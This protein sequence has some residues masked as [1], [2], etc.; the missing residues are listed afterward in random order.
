MSNNFYVIVSVILFSI[1][2]S[3]NSVAQQLNV[4]NDG[5]PDKTLTQ[6]NIAD[7][8]KIVA[9]ASDLSNY[10]TIDPTMTWG[11]TKEWQPPWIKFQPFGEL[12]QAGDLNGDGYEDYI[13][14]Y[15]SWNEFTDDLSD[16]ISKTLIYFGPDKLTEAADIIYDYLIP[17]GDV[18]GIGKSQLMS[19]QENRV[20][21]FYNFDGSSY[22]GTSD[23]VPQLEKWLTFFGSQYYTMLF[24]DLDGNQSDDLIGHLID[25]IIVGYLD[26][27]LRA[28]ILHTF[29]LND[30]FE[31]IYL[32]I[33][34]I[35]HVKWDN[36]NYLV[37]L[38]QDNLSEGR[39]QSLAV[40]SLD[41][42]RLELV[43]QLNFSENMAISVRL[44]LLRGSDGF[45]N[46]LA[47]GNDFSPNGSDE[48]RFTRL[49]EQ[50]D[51]NGLY[52]ESKYILREEEVSLS[53]I[54]DLNGN[55]WSDLIV[56]SNE[57]IKYATINPADSSLSIQGPIGKGNLIN[58][59]ISIGESLDSFK[60]QGDLNND[61]IDDF[62]YRV[63][64]ENAFGHLRVSG[65]GDQSNVDYQSPD[66]FLYEAADYRVTKI[67]ATYVFGDLTGNGLDD[68]GMFINDG[69]DNRLE[70][71]E[72][73]RPGSNPVMSVDIEEELTFATSGDFETDGREDLLLLTRYVNNLEDGY[74]IN[75]KLEIFKYG[76]NSPYRTIDDKDYNSGLG[77]IDV[78]TYMVNTANAGDINN[79]GLD[80]ILVSAPGTSPKNPIGIYLGG[81]NSITPDLTVAFP[82]GDG[83]SYQWGWG[84]TLQGGFDFNGDG[85]DDFLIG[86]IDETNIYNLPENA[87]YTKTGAVHIFYGQSG[88]LNFSSGSDVQLTSDSGAYDSNIFYQLFGLNEVGYGDFN[89]DGSTDI[90]VKPFSHHV[91]NDSNQG[92]AGIHIFHGGDN[93]DGEPDQLLPLLKEIH[94]PSR[95]GYGSDTTSF[96]GRINIAGVPDINA[97]GADELLVIQHNGALFF[98]GKTLSEVPDVVLEAPNNSLGLNSKLAYINR[99]FRTAIG[100]ITREGVTSVLLWQQGDTNYR[101]TPAY[102]YELSN[103][104]VSTEEIATVLPENFSLDQNYPNPFNP[105]TQIQF[106]LPEASDVKLTVYNVLGQQVATLVNEFMQAGS[107]TARFDAG[108][109]S[110]GMYIYR[111]EAG[112]AQLDGKMMLIK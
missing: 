33:Q 55:G 72:G 109:L 67:E 81:K 66:E 56:S 36:T 63:S 74:Q 110:S 112:S 98:G 1:L 39:P 100:E 65:A 87:T 15:D 86:N 30:Y 107:H 34:E 61:G 102:L 12:I 8:V 41:S 16:R 68:Y 47:S 92:R 54:G 101:D 42:D 103:L 6:H 32:A 85:I 58:S 19:R 49:F 53:A 95:L 43:Q 96:A 82:E 44:Q 76:E 51:G 37:V 89:G 93:F 62:L 26:E 29:E 60:P 73:G 48:G 40:F 106:S 90:A 79:D 7:S 10:N 88:T 104:A 83:I 105:S 75:A 14:N 111:L 24:E 45:P 21:L 11:H 84:G 77:E 27:N 108:S 80:D 31:N 18:L 50:S 38:L 3:S 64:S 13:S 94:R 59:S 69:V 9:K 28:S 35:H 57:D 25:E 52:T 17:V 46:I 78:S 2:C 70:I 99:Q 97:D 23:D 5:W 91:R 22:F 4:I 20:S 71:F